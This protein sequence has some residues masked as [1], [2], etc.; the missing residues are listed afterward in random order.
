MTSRSDKVRSREAEATGYGVKYG[1]AE[2]AWDGTACRGTSLVRFRHTAW[3]RHIAS[4][5]PR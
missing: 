5:L 3:W 2:T 4:R 1:T